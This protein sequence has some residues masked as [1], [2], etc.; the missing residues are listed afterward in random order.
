[1]DEWKARAHV[2]QALTE[3]QLLI[4]GLEKHPELEQAVGAPGLKQAV[5]TASKALSTW[6]QEA[7][8]FFGPSPTDKK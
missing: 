4:W 5:D 3:L 1:M 6:A 8:V 2:L 7:G